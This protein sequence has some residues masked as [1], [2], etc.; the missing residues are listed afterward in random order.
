MNGGKPLEQL[1][2]IGASGPVD[3]IDAHLNRFVTVPGKIN[4]LIEQIPRM[5]GPHLTPHV[6]VV[7]PHQMDKGV[8]IK[9]DVTSFAIIQKYLIEPLLARVIDPQ[10]M[11]NPPQKSVV[12][13]R[14]GIEVG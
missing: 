5:A 9:F 7:L 13:Q 2:K 14:F 11:A 3:K 4:Q 1:G 8:S 6:D 10:F 12:Y